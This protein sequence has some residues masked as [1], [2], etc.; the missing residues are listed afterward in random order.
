MELIDNH[1]EDFKIKVEDIKC[2]IEEEAQEIK[3]NVD[4]V[5]GTIIEGFNNLTGVLDVKMERVTLN[6]NGLYNAIC[7]TRE[8]PSLETKLNAKIEKQTEEIKRLK[9][10]LEKNELLIQIIRRL[11]H[12][13]R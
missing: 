13:T 8:E 9:R 2:K 7:E 1:I 11:G 5:K 12:I 4:E 10:K 6:T 3:D